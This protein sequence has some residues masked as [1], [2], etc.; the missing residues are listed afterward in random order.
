M[1]NLDWELQAYG[2]SKAD[3][4]ESIKLILKILDLLGNPRLL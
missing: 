4:L 2:A 1:S 3:I